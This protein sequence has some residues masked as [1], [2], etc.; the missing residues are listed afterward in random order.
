[1]ASTYQVDVIDLLKAGVDEAGCR[2]WLAAHVPAMLP[3]LEPLVERV[4]AESE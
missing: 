1:V 3:R 4:R 2:T